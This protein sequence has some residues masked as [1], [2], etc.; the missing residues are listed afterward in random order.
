MARTSWDAPAARAAIV[1]MDVPGASAIERRVLM[2]FMGVSAHGSAI[3]GFQEA[4]RKSE[5]P[6]DVSEQARRIRVPTLVVAG[7]EDAVMPVSASRSLA[8]AIPGARLEI[9]EGADHL[10]ASALDPRLM[11]MVSE[12][13]RQPSP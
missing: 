10:E 12:F 3:A 1:E 13:L 8:A 9:L 7:S 6:F 11:R 2:H 5:G 4:M